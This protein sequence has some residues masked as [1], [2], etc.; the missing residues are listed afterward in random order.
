MQQEAITLIVAGLGIAGTLGGTIVG[1]VFQARGQHQ[2]WRR[3]NIRQE[4]RELLGQLS[5]NLFAFIDWQKSLAAR[6]DGPRAAI[7][8]NQYSNAVL[9]LHRNFGSRI[10]IADEL[11]KAKIRDRWKSATDDFDGDLKKLNAEYEKIAEE[12]AKI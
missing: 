4:C 8:S 12:I 3:D 11:N 6:E 9:D 7:I 10:L 1:N 5:V 2:Q